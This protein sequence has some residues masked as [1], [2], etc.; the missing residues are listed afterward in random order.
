LFVHDMDLE[1]LVSSV[2]KSPDIINNRLKLNQLI[3]IHVILRKS[4]HETSSL[5]PPRVYRVR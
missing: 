4:G 3:L 1:A 2:F 5:I